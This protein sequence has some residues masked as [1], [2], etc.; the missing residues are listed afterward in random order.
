MTAHELTNIESDS[1]ISITAAKKL[2][3]NTDSTKRVSEDA[4]TEL[5]NDL[6]EYGE[7]VAEEA[8][9]LAKQRGRKTVRAVDIKDAIKTRGA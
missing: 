6:E 3:Q 1:G 9:D 8:L 7:A 5:I 2:I 4:A